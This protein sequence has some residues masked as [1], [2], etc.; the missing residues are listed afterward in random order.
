MRFAKQKALR[1][2][3]AMWSEEGLDGC[4]GLCFQPAGL[5]DPVPIELMILGEL[6]FALRVYSSKIHCPL[7]FTVT[8]KPGN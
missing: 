3:A 8:K 6:I 2:R 7:A 1:A 4:A 5:Q